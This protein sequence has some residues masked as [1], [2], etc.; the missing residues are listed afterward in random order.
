MNIKSWVFQSEIYH[1]D[2]SSHIINITNFISFHRFFSILWIADRSCKYSDRAKLG[3]FLKWSA[4]WLHRIRQELN[5]KC[6]CLRNCVKGSDTWFFFFFYTNNSNYYFV[7]C[8]NTCGC[9]TLEFKCSGKANWSSGFRNRVFCGVLSKKKWISVRSWR[10]V[11][12]VETVCVWAPE[13]TCVIQNRGQ[14][15]L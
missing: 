3:C 12:P 8:P 6:C 10:T 5:R 4:W 14:Y 9:D 11:F 1:H 7:F 15:F 13:L 2:L